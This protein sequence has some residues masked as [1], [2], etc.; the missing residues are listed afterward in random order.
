MYTVEFEP[1]ASIITS[2]D[3]GGEYNDIEVIIGDNGGVYLRQ[4]EDLLDE[5]SVVYISY[6]QL[7]E[8]YAA[9]H[10]T[11]GCYRLEIQQ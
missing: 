1:D 9:I 11:D 8:I 3:D 5:Y 4:F 7:I 10:S 6:K 2:I